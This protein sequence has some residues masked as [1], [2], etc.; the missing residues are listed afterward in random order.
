MKKSKAPYSKTATLQKT[1]YHERPADDRQCNLMSKRLRHS[2]RKMGP[3]FTSGRHLASAKTPLVVLSHPH[4]HIPNRQQFHSK[5]IRYS[6]GKPLDIANFLP[7]KARLPK[8]S[9]GLTPYKYTLSP[10]AYYAAFR[11]AK[12]L[13]FP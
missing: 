1:A 2:T 4:F 6:I 5:R 8:R 7:S 11:S 13:N 10:N 3:Y 12:Y 9:I